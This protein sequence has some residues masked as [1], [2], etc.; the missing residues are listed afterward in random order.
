MN[1]SNRTSAFS[2]GATPRTF[3]STRSVMSHYQ[4]HK[5]EAG[6]IFCQANCTHCHQSQSF[7]QVKSMTPGYYTDREPSARDMRSYFPVISPSSSSLLQEK[8]RMCKDRERELAGYP[9]KPSLHSGGHALLRNR[10]HV[11][12]RPLSHY[13]NQRKLGKDLSST[14]LKRNQSAAFEEYWGQ[15]CNPIQV[16]LVVKPAS[17]LVKCNHVYTAMLCGI[18]FYMRPGRFSYFSD[19]KG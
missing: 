6:S 9:G 13:K 16:K 5:K 8:N 3:S 12:W 7:F 14:M 19:F 15:K 17:S 18:S 1:G 10:Q 11:Q 2:K 4:S